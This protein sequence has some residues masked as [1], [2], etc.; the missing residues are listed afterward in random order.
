M[1]SDFQSDHDLSMNVSSDE[2]FTFMS[3]FS[4]QEL[5][6]CTI[7]SYLINGM[8]CTCNKRNHT[9]KNIYNMNGYLTFYFISEPSLACGFDDVYKCGYTVS[10]D[11]WPYIWHQ[12]SATL[13]DSTRQINIAKDGKNTFIKL[14]TSDPILQIYRSIF[15]L[16]HKYRYVNYID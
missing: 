5:Q 3:I 15:I 7:S 8:Q 10:Q 12:S 11:S 6:S 13:G 16:S 14:W 4:C 9:L 2:I 1:D